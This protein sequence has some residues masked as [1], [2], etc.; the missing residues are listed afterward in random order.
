MCARPTPPPRAANRSR[1]CRDTGRE[2]H[3]IF[4]TISAQKSAA[5]AATHRRAFAE[6]RPWSAAEFSALL[7]SPGTVLIGDAKGFLLGRIVAGEAE[8]LTL[9]TDP[10][11]QRQGRAAQVL[12]EF[13]KTARQGG[14]EA[15]FLEVAADNTPARALY[16]RAGFAEAGRR[17]GYYPRPQAPAADALMLR[18]NLT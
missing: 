14:A 9:A 12:A 8:V 7:D 3:T 4:V 11:H 15:V 5:L 18:L 2:N 10:A 13:C 6:G 17:A 1:S 16:A